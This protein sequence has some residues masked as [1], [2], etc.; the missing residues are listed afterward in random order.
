[1]KR[2]LYLSRLLA[3]AAA[4]VAAQAAAPAAPTPA[5]PAA[6]AEGCGCEG[7]PLPEVLAVV[8]GVKLTRADLGQRARARVAELQRRVIDARRAE[9]DL[10]VRE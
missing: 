1:M 5:T 4:D 2:L 3:A 9:L 10:Q 8:G 7:A 6:S